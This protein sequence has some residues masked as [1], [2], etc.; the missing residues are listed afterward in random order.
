MPIYTYVL[1]RSSFSFKKSQYVNAYVCGGLNAKN[2]KKMLVNGKYNHVYVNWVPSEKKVFVRSKFYI[3]TIYD[4]DVFKNMMLS[5]TQYTFHEV[6]MPDA[7]VRLYVDIEDKTK[8][9]NISKCMELVRKVIEVITNKLMSEFNIPIIS[10]PKILDASVDG[11]IFSQHLI[12]SD[13]WFS[14]SHTLRAFVET[15]NTEFPNS[16]IDT[17]VYPTSSPRSLRLPF[18]VKDDGTR[19]LV[20]VPYFKLSMDT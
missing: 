12:F 3:P 15:I 17:A 4:K 20:P 14:N 1:I 7:P 10:Q 13:I 8:G 5:N 6:I 9:V 19:M 18:C 11:E 16:F 2:N